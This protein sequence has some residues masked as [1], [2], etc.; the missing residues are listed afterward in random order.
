MAQ[1]A[2]RSQ[3]KLLGQE[4]TPDWLARHLADR[5]LDLPARRAKRPRIVDMCCGSGS[6]LAEVIKAAREKFGFTDID[7]AAR[8]C[9]RL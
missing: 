2:R 8:R 4:W 6:I 3:R 7:S 5:C 1:L 9:D